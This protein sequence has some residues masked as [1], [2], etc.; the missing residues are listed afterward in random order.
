MREL[1]VH[2]D[3]ASVEITL[4]SSGA[5]AT[6]GEDLTKILDAVETEGFSGYIEKKPAEWVDKTGVPDSSESHF[7]Q[8]GS[9]TFEDDVDQ[10][11]I[12]DINDV[13]SEAAVDLEYKLVEV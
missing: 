9:F 2:V 4:K 8:S 13:I 7:T 10:E 5:E 3:D 12:S 6:I 1:H 11:D